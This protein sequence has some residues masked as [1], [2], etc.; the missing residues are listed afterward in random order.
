MCEKCCKSYVEG[1]INGL[2]LDS[3]SDFTKAINEISKY[4]SF[5]C[6]KIDKLEKKVD[7][8]KTKLCCLEGCADC[9]CCSDS[10]CCCDES[11]C[12]CPDSC[13]CKVKCSNCGTIN[14]VSKSCCDDGCN[15][16]CKSDES[17][18]SCCCQ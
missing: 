5:L 7:T 14:H 18:S 17:G 4:Q 15:C 9:C 16:C 8:L 1:Y 13:S 2:N 3:S 10:C 12:S 6:C 11:S